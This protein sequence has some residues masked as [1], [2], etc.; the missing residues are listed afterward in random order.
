MKFIC[1]LSII[2]IFHII[3]INSQVFFKQNT[4]TTSNQE[5]ITTTRTISNVDDKTNTVKTISITTTTI[6]D[7]KSNTNKTITTTTTMIT[8]TN[9][10]TT[11]ET[12][13]PKLPVPLPQ[14]KPN[15]PIFGGI[16]KER[17]PT[18]ED[19]T[20]LKDALE[21]HRKDLIQSNY[22]VL[23]LQE[24]VVQG[25]K[26]YFHIKVK[27]NIYM[28]IEVIIQA[29]EK[30]PITIDTMILN[31]DVSKKTEEIYQSLL[32]QKSNTK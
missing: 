25:K 5:P 18:D 23:Y 31:P 28:L 26:Y 3:H 29:W 1:T 19:I 32:K 11:V 30:D 20:I 6:L 13:K 21:K 15:S 22:T 17:L 10:V 14:P 24:Q 16:S 9:T 4:E 2:F 8:N 12:I 7:N 27:N